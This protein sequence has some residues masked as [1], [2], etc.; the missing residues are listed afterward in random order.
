M[1]WQASISGWIAESSV[2]ETVLYLLMNVPGLPPIVQTVHIAAVAVVMASIVFIA[3]RVLNIAVPSQQPQ[4]MVRRL[5]PWLWWALPVLFLSG[6]VF[7]IARP[8][9]YFYNPIAGW[10]VLFIVIAVTTALVLQQRA[11][12]LDRRSAQALALILL[13]AIIGVVLAG[14]WIAYVDYIYWE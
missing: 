4:E 11:H 5:M 10:K 6:I 7:V 1:D 8:D 3:L 13:S 9:R 2:R 14:R 12:K